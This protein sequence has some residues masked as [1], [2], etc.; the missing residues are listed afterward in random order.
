[1]TILKCPC[2]FV[3]RCVY[4]D[5]VIIRAARDCGDPG[6]LENGQVTLSSGTT[7][8]SV[9]TYSC[10]TGYNAIGETVR[11]CGTDGLWTN[12]VPICMSELF[13]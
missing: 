11:E 1:M 6:E 13:V 7:L 4:D 5:I 10:T 3:M 8:G 9:A 12:S 2:Q